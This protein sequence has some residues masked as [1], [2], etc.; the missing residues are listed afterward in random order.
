MIRAVRQSFA[1]GELAPELHMRSDLAAYQKG[2]ALL[3]NMIVRRTGSAQKRP[4]TDA[5]DVAAGFP[6]GG[7]PVR[8]IPFY[9]DASLSLVLLVAAGAVR[10][11]QVSPDF[12]FDREFEWSGWTAEDVAGMRARQAGDTLFVT[13]PGR[14][15]CRLVRTASTGA[16]SIL[17][18]RV[19]PLPS[20]AVTLSASGNAAFVDPGK[21]YT[22]QTFRYAVFEDVGGLLEMRKSAS[23]TG[24]CAPWP[25]GGRVTLSLGITGFH[26]ESRFI[27]AKRWG[28]GYGV[29]GDVTQQSAADTSFTF[30]DD[31]IAPNEQ[32]PYQSVIR[33]AADDAGGYAIMDIHQQRQVLCGNAAAPWTLWFSRLGDL[34][35]W[36][37]NRPADDADPFRATLPAVRASEIR[38]TVA[39]RRLLLF[40][41]DGIFAVH[42]GGEGFAART[43]QIE[44]VSPVGAGAAPPTDTGAAVL[45]TAED[46]RALLEMRYSFAEDA[47]V[48][49]DRS[50]LARHL[51]EGASVVR[52]AW[53]AWPDGIL[54]ALLDDGSLLA[55]TYLP[56]HEVFAWSRHEVR[57][58][59]QAHAPEDGPP[60]AFIADIA[61]TGAVLRDTRVREARRDA[62]SVC[63]LLAMN[64]NVDP[65]AY[66]LLRM[67][68]GGPGADGCIDCARAAVGGAEGVTAA[69][70]PGDV[71]RVDG[72]PWHT[73]TEA[74][75]VSAAQLE[76]LEWGVPV[77]AALETLRPESPDRPAQAL[78]RRVVSVTVR[79]LDS[80][81]YTVAD[82][83]GGAET[84]TAGEPGNH[85]AAHDEKLPPV[86]GWDWDGR[87]R[88]ASAGPD[89][90]EVLGVVADIE[91]EGGR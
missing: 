48:T 5:L 69:L 55:F 39:G 62:T 67:R 27:F 14:L 59:G 91:F 85:A 22:P 77:E 34:Y 23:Y 52:T 57:L 16:W 29:I 26:P 36:Y 84:E 79:T 46:D 74:G 33:S 9:Y 89:K 31:N 7:G 65:P 37:S 58:A 21:G 63:V 71:W 60:P 64:G 17:T 19:T 86:S 61:A 3:Y 6:A 28:A 53:Q 87:V 73:A 75:E 30:Y 70:Q 25:P 8:L 56:E 41:T 72:G 2:A 51:T 81:R 88:I 90:L 35:A 20:S 49:V 68:A 38:H 10:V 11:Y 43:C 54:W 15:P 13:A 18:E 1:A 78:R 4:G 32:I 45:F 47:H 82:A 12:G 50:V 80:G 44:R 76:T 40:T 42:A 66:T 83:A 24:G